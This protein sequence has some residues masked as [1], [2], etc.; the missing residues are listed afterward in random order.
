MRAYAV[1][2]I[3]HRQTAAEIR[4]QARYEWSDAAL[5]QRV[6]DGLEIDFCRIHLKLEMPDPADRQLIIPDIIFDEGLTIDLGDVTC[7][8][9][10]VGGDHAADSCVMVIPQDKILF[11]GDCAYP[12]IYCE[13][14]RYTTAK[15]FPLLDHLL[16]SPAETY[17]WGHGD[18]LESR[19]A[20]SQYADTLRGIGRL[21]ENLGEQRET[22]ITEW[23]AQSGIP[24]DEETLELIE[25]FVAGL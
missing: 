10:H 11:L 22:I 2:I 18:G 15:L 20:F 21:V 5:D 13:P 17:I 9:Q 24:A 1:P 16:A 25:T 3:A 19:G 23:Q 6:T 4:R 7:Q 14:R 8:I 12:D